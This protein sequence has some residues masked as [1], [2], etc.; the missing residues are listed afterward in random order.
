V[1]MPALFGLAVLFGTCLLLV[2]KRNS[3]RGERRA[4]LAGPIA[5]PCPNGKITCAV[6]R[7]ASQA[8]LRKKS[9]WPLATLRH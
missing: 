8:A 3:C 9:S 2:A 7:T 6:L 1:M 5:S 4:D